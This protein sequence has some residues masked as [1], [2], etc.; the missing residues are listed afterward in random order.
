MD[1]SESSHGGE[2]GGGVHLP[3]P[4]VWP[5][6]VGL[7]FFICG[8]ALIFYSRDRDSDFAGPLLGAAAVIALIAGCGWAYED[9]RM[10]RKAE[11]GHHGGARDARYTQVVTFAV[12]EGQYAAARG[13]NGI[14][15]LLEATDNSL[16]DLDGFQ[17]MRVIASPSADGISQV[18][19]E[20]TWADRDGLA[21]YEETR[22]TMVDLL[23]QH[24]DEVVGGSVQVFDMEVVRDTKDT[25]FNF[26]TS[27]MVGTF[28]ALIVGGFMVGAGLNLFESDHASGVTGPGPSPVAANVITANNLRFTTGTEITA[29]PNTAITLVF[30]NKEG[31]FHNVNVAADASPGGPSLEGC[32]AGCADDGTAVKTELAS[33]PFTHEFT[34]TT[35]GV[36]EYGF[37]CDAHTQMTGKIVIAEGAPIPGAAAAPAGGE[38]SPGASPATTATAAP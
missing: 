35:P 22:S 26:G 18:L 10:K 14:I 32:T 13:E 7:A 25:S 27:A 12:P 24:P 31:Q 8:V 30:E 1:H 33:G 37:Q 28:G 11:E 9:G 15:S 3:D 6:V 29:P 19:V 38:A 23:A 21:T 34:F 36:G 20:T 2:H 5:L 17:D 16:R 4:S